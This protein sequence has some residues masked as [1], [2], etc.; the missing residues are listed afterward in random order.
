MTTEN[1]PEQAEVAPATSSQL[2]ADAV[3][4]IPLIDD[5]PEAEAAAEVAQAAPVEAALPAAIEEP[6]AEESDRPKLPA[7]PKQN[8]TQ[9]APINMKAQA[10]R[11]DELNLPSDSQ[12][13]INAA[14]QQMPNV[15]LLDSQKPRE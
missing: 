9:V 1:K 2:D 5:S 7:R 13:R 6:S 3:L 11:T 15:D 8:V 4:G 14:L 10:A 12:E